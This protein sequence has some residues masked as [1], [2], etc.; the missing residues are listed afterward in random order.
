MGK[1][2][3]TVTPPLTKGAAIHY[4]TRLNK[5][6][7]ERITTAYIPEISALRYDMFCKI[8]FLSCGNFCSN[9]H[10]NNA[11]VYA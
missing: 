7:R 10:W 6:F 4:I 2:P 1:L 8:Q 9:I 3:S 5:K 11:E